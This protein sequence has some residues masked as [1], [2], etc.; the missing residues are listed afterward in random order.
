MDFLQISDSKLKLTLTREDM[1]KH[2][3]KTE[4]V[5]MENPQ[6]RFIL[7]QILDEAKGHTGF[8]SGEKILIKCYPSKDGGCEL[9]VTAL[10]SPPATCMEVKAILS[11]KANPVYRFLSVKSLLQ[12]SVAMQKQP[13]IVES[14][15]YVSADGS[16]DLALS[17]RENSS[18]VLRRFSEFSASASTLP[19]SYIEEHEKCVI[20]T[21]A[22]QKLARL[23]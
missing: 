16:Y 18:F 8:D 15:L 20:P 7:R 4:C 9:F 23:V 11:T 3:F 6:D 21:S 14:K 22:I 5:D 13:E 12:A 17:V 1:E 10:G 2:G 19:D